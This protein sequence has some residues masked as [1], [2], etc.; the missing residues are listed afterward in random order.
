MHSAFCHIELATTDLAATEAFYGAL[1]G[2]KLTDTEMGSGSYTMIETGEQP[3]GEMMT[4]PMPGMPSAWTSYVA[5]EDLDASV[6]RV[7]ALGGIA[8]L[9]RTPN[10]GI[11]AFAVI[12]DPTGAVLG[13]FEPL[14]R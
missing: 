11:G 10:P 8:H 5:V 7:Q 3:G 6:A 9:G 4:C 14:E 2:W 13:L 1:F 12:A